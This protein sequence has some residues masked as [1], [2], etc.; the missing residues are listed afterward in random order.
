[1][2]T[3]SLPP[4]ESK[5]APEL[6]DGLDKRGQFLYNSIDEIRQ[7]QSWLILRSQEDRGM[8]GDLK[9]EVAA[10]KVQTEKT[11]GR[12]TATE[13]KV[14]ALEADP[15]LRL[16]RLGATLVRSKMF[17]AGTFLFLV[18]G[19]PWLGAHSEGVISFLRTISL[20]GG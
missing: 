2:P 16:S 11:N 10:V 8:L 5:L 3:D 17:W 6:L 4:F 14:A 13:S 9:T 7:A 20:L 18:V 15:G 19:V 12:T 1:M